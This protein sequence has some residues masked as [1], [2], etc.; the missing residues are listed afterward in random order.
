VTHRRHR[1][2]RAAPRAAAPGPRFELTIDALAAGGDAVGRDPDG[3]VTFVPRGAPGD[4]LLVEVVAEQRRLARAELL[5]VIAPSAERVE[6]PCPLFLGER[7]GGCQWQ[8]V[9]AA[10]QAAAKQAIVAG[11]LRAAVA[12][13]LRLEPL[14]SPAPPLGWRRRAR[15]HWR[16][17]ESGG[18]AIGLFRQGSHELI[19]VDRCPQLE[20]ALD[21]ALTAVRRRLEP[22]MR[23]EGEVQMVAG[24]RGEVHVAI[25]GRCDVGGCATLVGVAGIVG[26]AVR[27]GDS[28]GARAVELEPGL[29]ARADTFAQPSRAGNAAIIAAVEGLTAPRVGARVL[30]LHAGSGN[31]TRA[32]RRGAAEVVA[33]ERDAPPPDA[34]PGHAN[35]APVRW[36]SGDAA[37][38]VDELAAAGERFDLVVLDPPR[39][40]AADAIA[41]IVRLAP[42]AIVYVSCD[43]ATLARDAAALAA[44]GYRPDRAQPIDTM[45]Q[46]AHVEVVMRLLR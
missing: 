12:S 26:V 19:D 21:A 5:A 41:G 14:V 44:A 8:H 33:V 35:E 38:V 29:F 18:L 30:E 15:L 13:G 34:A 23:G 37:T 10:G 36:R 20:P 6:P 2:P 1:R 27:F 25:S 7:C 22:S 43:P 28:W 39:T 46:T 42:A 16:R 32:L 17:H 40:G 9:S 45:P 3:R 4:R 24:H 31:L 11:A